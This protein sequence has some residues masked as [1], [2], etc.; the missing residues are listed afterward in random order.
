MRAPAA[1][2]VAAAIALTTSCGGA[3]AGDAATTETGR[4][5]DPGAAE[6]LEVPALSDAWV[7]L[8]IRRLASLVARA[9]A[10]DTG[11]A[12]R[13]RLWPV[14]NDLRAG[15][16]S[17]AQVAS[18]LRRLEQLEA[19]HPAARE[20][21]QRTAFVVEHLRIGAV[22][23]NIVDQDSHGQA[24]QLADY[25]GKV[26][27][28]VFGGNWCGPCRSEYPYQRLLTEKYAGEPFAIVGVNSDVLEVARTYAAENG[29]EYRSF[30]DGPTTRGPIA[31][32]W[33][34]TSWPTVYVLDHEGRIRFFDVRYQA[35]LQAVAQLMEAVQQA[36]DPRA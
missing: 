25:R 13:F 5:L 21:L 10:G 30:W 20:Q 2:G 33:N 11:R 23:P 34:V 7:R 36:R 16:L 1:F 8:R 35:T 6:R 22:A 12:M 3:Q 26:V 31:T 28:L 18:V 15:S 9:T 19:E 24:F 14:E 29:L 27:V 4:G 32:R 17:D